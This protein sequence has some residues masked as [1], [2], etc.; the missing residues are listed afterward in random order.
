MP[1]SYILF[2]TGAAILLMKNI[3]AC[4]SLRRNW[5]ASFSLS[6]RGSFFCA[7]SSSQVAVWY[8]LITLSAAASTNT[9]CAATA[10]AIITVPINTVTP[11]DFRM[12]HSLFLLNGSG[13]LQGADELSVTPHMRRHLCCCELR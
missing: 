3:R 12:S 4:G 11:V 10:P 8:F 6:V 7:F 13:V 9:P 2:R 1:Q 5:T